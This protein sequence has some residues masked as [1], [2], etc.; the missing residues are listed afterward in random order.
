VRIRVLLPDK[1]LDSETVRIASKHEWG[2]LLQ[3]GVEIHEYDPTMFHCKMLILDGEMVSV[4]STN[5]DMRSFQLNDEASL[6][7]YD[8][9]FAGRMTQVFEQDLGKSDSYTYAMWKARPWT[10]KLTEF[11]VVPFRSQL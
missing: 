4:G 9:A 2:P 5:L 10:Q 6:N 11:V 3:A 7:V 1:H 8:K